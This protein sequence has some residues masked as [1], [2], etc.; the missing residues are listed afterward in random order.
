MSASIFFAAVVMAPIAEE[1]VFR[2]ILYP[3]IKQLGFPRAALWA[4]SLTFALIHGNRMTVL[5]FTLLA[6]VLTFVYERTNNLLSS[7]AM[8]AF[9]NLVNFLRVALLPT[10]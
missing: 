4:T 7:M 1:I 10:G 9:F 3:S 8:H 6:L 5:P 2:G